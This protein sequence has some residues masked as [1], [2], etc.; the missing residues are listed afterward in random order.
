MNEIIIGWTYSSREL[1]KDIFCHQKSNK[2]VNKL[3]MGL[4]STPNLSMQRSLYPI[5]Q[6]QCSIFLLPL[7]FEKY[8][9]PQV[10]I[11]KMVNGHP[12]LLGLT[13]RISMDF[14]GLYF[15]LQDICWIFSEISISQHGSEKFSNSS[16]LN[17][18]KIHSKILKN[19][20]I[21]FYSSP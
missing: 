14:S 18:W 12:S 8:L 7:F 16:Y 19:S 15:S 17:Y 21:H 5:F 4:S 11:N 6:K 13:S 1:L 2:K 9:N 3:F 10:I 20:S